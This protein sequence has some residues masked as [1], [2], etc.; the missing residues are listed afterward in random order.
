MVCHGWTT[1]GRADWSADNDAQKDML[2]F[3]WDY[4]VSG[5]LQATLQSCSCIPMPSQLFGHTAIIQ[6]KFVFNVS[7]TINDI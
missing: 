1:T 4:R 2:F 7:I 6:P 5:G 3:N